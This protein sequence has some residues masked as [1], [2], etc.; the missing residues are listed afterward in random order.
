MVCS[1][2]IYGIGGQ[3]SLF[4]CFPN[5]PF[6]VK[7]FQRWGEKMKI[8]SVSLPSDLC[9]FEEVH[10]PSNMAALQS[11][12]TLGGSVGSSR[13][14]CLRREAYCHRLLNPHSLAVGTSLQPSEGE[15][16]SWK[17][18][19]MPSVVSREEKLGSMI[20][21]D[22]D[23]WLKVRRITCKGISLSIGYSRSQAIGIDQV[24]YFCKV[25]C[26][27]DYFSR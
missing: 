24:T 10:L 5:L 19:Q 25:E 15:R 17:W 2:Q 8:K 18:L 20:L 27:W 16:Y 26:K 12:C 7:V 14:C 9:T 6:F 23:T 4:L 11:S 21:P 1:N 22:W 3:K 13:Q